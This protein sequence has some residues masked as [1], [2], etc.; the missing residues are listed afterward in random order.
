M[1]SKRWAT[2]GA[3]LFTSACATFQPYPALPAG[4]DAAQ[5]QLQRKPGESSSPVGS[6][7]HGFFLYDNSGCIENE[8]SG[9]LGGIGW[10]GASELERAIP[11]GSSVYLRMNARYQGG[12]GATS[13]Y[14]IV[15]CTSVARFTPRSGATYVAYHDT[16][17]PTCPA[18]VID[19]ATGRAPDDFELVPA[20]GLCRK[21]N[22]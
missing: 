18:V 20:E 1:I 15:E 19:K 6:A 11:A 7:G 8:S 4:A 22:T 14:S 10:N 2:F 9:F 13:L 16:F 17:S 12:G 21:F 3:I 5:I